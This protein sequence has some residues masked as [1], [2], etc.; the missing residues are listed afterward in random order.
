M[1]WPTQPSNWHFVLRKRNEELPNSVLPS[2]ESLSRKSKCSQF[3]NFSNFSN[4]RSSTKHGD[5][6]PRFPPLRKSNAWNVV[7]TS[8]PPPGDPY[9]NPPDPIHKNPP[10]LEWK[11][12]EKGE[13]KGPFERSGFICFFGKAKRHCRVAFVF[14][15]SLWGSRSCSSD[16]FL[17]FIARSAFLQFL[18]KTQ[19]T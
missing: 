6:K 8:R 18:W 16:Y 9:G 17:L 19:A 4:L 1:P 11:E 12:K 13:K 2:D 14:A 15:E 3:S 5:R 7:N 10:D